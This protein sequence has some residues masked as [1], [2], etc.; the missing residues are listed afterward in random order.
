MA[1]EQQVKQIAEFVEAQV[2]ERIQELDAAMNDEDELAK[3]RQKRLKQLKAQQANKETWLAA[4][5]GTYSEVYSEVEFNAAVLKSKRVVVHFHRGTTKYC[6]VVHRHLTDLAAK[7]LETRFIKVD[8]ERLEQIASM[9]SITVLPSVMFIVDNHT[10]YT[11][12]GFND[13]GG[14]DDF[15]TAQLEALMVRK[16]VIHPE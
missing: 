9:Y 13:L 3:L 6:D 14:R 16:K 5:H 11:M 15:S 8:V 7:H 4:G 12:M 2:D 1:S 10:E